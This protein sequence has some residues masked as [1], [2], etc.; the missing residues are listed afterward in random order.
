MDRAQ[1]L[2]LLRAALRDEKAPAGELAVILVGDRKM[3]QINRDFRS[4][5]KSTDVLSFSY[6]DDPYSGGV[7]GEIYVSPAIAAR[8]AEEAECGLDEEIARLILHGLLHVLGWEHD[9]PRSR[10]RMLGRQERYLD[11]YWR[12]AEAAA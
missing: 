11:R 1:L 7:L 2:G 8:Q 3:Q 5:D 4:I 6:V 9:T 12:S 10:R